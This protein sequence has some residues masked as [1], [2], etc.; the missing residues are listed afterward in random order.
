MMAQ[1]PRHS[2][3][4]YYFFL[5]FV[6][7]SAASYAQDSEESTKS[8]IRTSRFHMGLYFSTL[9][10]GSGTTSVYDGYGYDVNGNKNDFGNSFMYR[11]IV[12][13]YGG[14]GSQPDRVAEALGVNH[15]D[16]SFDE[17]DMPG[18]MKYNVGLAL[19]F[20]SRF[21]IDD[22][23]SIM[24][25]FTASKL[26]LGGDFTITILSNPQQPQPPGYLNVRTFGI[27]GSEQR[28]VFQLGYQ[29]MFGEEGGFN[30]FTEGGAV[31]TLAKF[32]TNP[33][34]INSLKVD[35]A[36]YYNQPQYDDF[37]LHHL[38]GVGFGGWAGCGLTSAAYAKTTLQL[39]YNLSL[40][41]IALGLN[42]K[43]SMQH[44]VGLRAYY[45]L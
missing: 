24:L 43:L 10:P 11:N 37:R 22:N 25:N 39:V 19:G 28:F 14:S 15:G 38:K 27:T 23:N 36:S 13:F 42:P 7:L 35:L 45:N 20:Q 3:I 29:H 12:I 9:F 34:A 17:S 40:E 31:C 33:I 21:S 16:W 41:T 6:L 4:R 5:A 26:S 2:L 44:Y 8:A 1:Y 30:F 18:N 32:L